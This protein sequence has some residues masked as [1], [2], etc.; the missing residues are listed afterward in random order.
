[1]NTERGTMSSVQ[2]CR[3]A[4]CTYRQLDYWTRHGLVEPLV[5]ADG[6]GSRRRWSVDDVH[7]VRRLI[8]AARFASGSIMDALDLL[9]DMTPTESPVDWFATT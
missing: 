8:L 6:S 2:L 9:D 1:M 4:G 5:A 7:R 3:E